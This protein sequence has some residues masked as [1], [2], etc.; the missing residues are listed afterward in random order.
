MK[1]SSPN[2]IRNLGPEEISEMIADLRQSIREL[3]FT[4][5]ISQLS[6]VKEISAKK[7]QVARLL[8]IAREKVDE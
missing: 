1:L 6:N 2:E 3:R 8:T 7:R 4:A 5:K